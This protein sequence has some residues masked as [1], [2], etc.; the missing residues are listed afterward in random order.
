MNIGK[1][2]QVHEIEPAL[3]PFEGEEIQTEEDTPAV[4]VEVEEAEEVEVEEEETVKSGY[5]LLI[6]DMRVRA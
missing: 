4:E 3:V 5:D 2:V 1:E 6:E